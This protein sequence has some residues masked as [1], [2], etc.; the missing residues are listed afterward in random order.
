M[1]LL[2][3]Y[4]KALQEIYDHVGFKEDWVVCP[5][6]DQTNCFW[7]VDG[8][9]VIYA[10][11]MEKIN[12]DGDYYMDDIYKQRFYSKHVYEGKDITMIFCDPGVDGMKWFRI[13]DNNKRV[14][15]DNSRS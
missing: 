2:T 11:T 8:D 13:F 4:T 10:E 1:E 15:N 7:Y 9:S 6:D 14:K 5:I 3:N 12:S